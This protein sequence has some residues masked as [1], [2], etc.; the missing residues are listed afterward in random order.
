METFGRILGAMCFAATGANLG[1]A[2]AKILEYNNIGTGAAC[3]AGTITFYYLF[4][5]L[6]ELVGSRQAS[7]N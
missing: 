5:L 3:V 6:S 2:S 7:K 1:S 4:V